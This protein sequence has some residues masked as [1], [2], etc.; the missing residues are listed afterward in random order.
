MKR[1]LSIGILISVFTLC[2]NAQPGIWNPVGSVGS[3]ADYVYPTNYSAKSFR[4]N[5]NGFVIHHDAANL[6]QYDI[7]ND[8]WSAGGIVPAASPMK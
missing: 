5:D 7:T 1:I 2:S 3:P 6:L 4:Y 8:E